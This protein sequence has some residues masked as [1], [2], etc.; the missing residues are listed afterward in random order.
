AAE[1]DVLLSADG[2][3]KVETSGSDTAATT[4]GTTSTEEQS[5]PLPAIGVVAAVIAVVAFVVIRRNW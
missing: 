4:P 2:A 1:G 3:A 5:S